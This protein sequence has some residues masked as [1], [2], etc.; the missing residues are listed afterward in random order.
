M[1]LASR[2]LELPE[3]ATLKAAARAR[4]LRAQGKDIL[5][6]ALG[7]PD[8]PSPAS[9]LGGVEKILSEG[10]TGYPPLRGMPDLLEKIREK[11]ESQNGIKTKINQ[12]MVGNGGKQLLFNACL[13]V[14][15]SGDEVIIPAPYW[16]SYPLTVQFSGGKSV[17][18]ETLEEN[19]FHPT[20]A[21]IEA[22]I[23]P[24]TKVLILN[25][26][27]NPTGA[28]LSKEELEQIAQLMR[29]YPEIWIFTDEMYEHLTFDGQKS[30]SLSAIAPDMSDRILTMNG[31]SKAYSM[32]GWRVGFAHGPEELIS[33]M[34]VLQ[35]NST[36][37]ICAP[38]QGAALAALNDGLSGVEKMRLTYE[39]RRDLLL[40]HLADVPGLSCRKPE[41]AFYAFTNVE[42]WLGKTTK[43]GTLLEDDSEIVNALLEEV[44]LAVVHGSAFGKAGYL[45]LSFAA[46][47]EDLIEGCQRLKSFAETLQ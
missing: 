32:T 3:S 29:K 11:F 44:G 16:V 15:N 35:G 47:D 38:A 22:A 17:I 1:K 25:S 24:K 6:L 8:F 31:M 9:T 30:Y 36:S 21:Q 41:G 23:T 43:A 37:G 20:V 34:M 33:A 45:R 40:S 27:S 4:E 46:S 5:S 18:I 26:P 12:L 13:A 14:I 2:L 42:K 39:K 10:R 28:V 19:N 7:E